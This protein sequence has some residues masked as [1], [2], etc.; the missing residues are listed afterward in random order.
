MAVTATA[1]PHVCEHVR[2]TTA[3]KTDVP[4]E[5]HVLSSSV[6]HTSDF[7]DTCVS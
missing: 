2:L 3:G 4:C 6:Y 1:S 5:Q 7:C